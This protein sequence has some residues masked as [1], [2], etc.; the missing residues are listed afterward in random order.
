MLKFNEK[1][2]KYN[3]GNFNA[4][5]RLSEDTL[6][7]V[8]WWKQNIFKVFKPIRY[9]KINITIYANASFRG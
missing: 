8:S 3:K 2:L 5:I 6:H 4:I 9:P 1:S 7:E